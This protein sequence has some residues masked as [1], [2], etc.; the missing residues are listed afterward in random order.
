MSFDTSR[1]VSSR[2]LQIPFPFVVVVRVSIII[3]G[4]RS[5]LSRSTSLPLN[6]LTGCA[7]SRSC[8]NQLYISALQ[9]VKELHYPKIFA[10]T[11]LFQQIFHRQCFNNESIARLISSRHRIPP[12]DFRTESLHNHRIYSQTVHHHLQINSSNTRRL[13]SVQ[14]HS[15]KYQGMVYPVLYR[16]CLTRHW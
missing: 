2:L 8:N 12:M 6:H 9:A 5:R 16:V 11:S 3:I 4:K 7:K 10:F 13:D 1:I 15:R 14:I